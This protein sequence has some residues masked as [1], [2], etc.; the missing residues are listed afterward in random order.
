MMTPR[1]VLAS[2]LTAVVLGTS[3][4][5]VPDGAQSPTVTQS[6]AT[7]TANPTEVAAQPESLSPSVSRPLTVVG[8]SACDLVPK[9]QLIDLGLDPTTVEDHSNADTADCRWYSN[10]K[11]FAGRL[12]LSNVRGLESAYLFRETFQ[13]FEPTEISGY[14]AIRT[15]SPDR[16][17]TCY[18]MTGIGPDRSVGVGFENVW[19]EQGTD[20]CALARSLATAA[21]A[22]LSA[23]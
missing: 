4:C 12:G 15:T 3:G 14:P 20:Y 1:N 9:Q 16:W 2:I 21:I 11:R 7:P 17:Y 10:G 22:E 18:Y 6:S 8:V 23:E 5:S 19:G 13:Y